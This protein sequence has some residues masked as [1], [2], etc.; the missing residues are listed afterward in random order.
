MLEI[1]EHLPYHNLICVLA[2]FM[3]S[4]SH[5]NR[6]EHLE[7]TITVA[8]SIPWIIYSEKLPSI[9]RNTPDLKAKI[10]QFNSSYWETESMECNV[11]YPEGPFIMPST[12]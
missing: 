11:H 5:Y 10:H 2:R 12:R 1:L 3:K 7:A 9:S 8:D 4:C 6:Q